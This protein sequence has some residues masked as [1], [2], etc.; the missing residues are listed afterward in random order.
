MDRRDF[1]TIGGLGLA[2]LVLPIHGRA[3]AAEEL[4]STLDV[5]VKKA[6]ADAALEA[7]PRARRHLLPTCA[8]GR[9]LQP[10]RHHPGGQVQNIANTESYGVGVRV[11]ADGTWGFAATTTSPRTASPRRRAQAVA[12]A[13]ANARLQTEPVQ[14]A[15][16][17]GVR[18]G[19]AGR[20]RSRRTPSRCRSRRR[21]TCCWRSTP[22]RSRR[23]PSS[24]TPRSSSSTSRSTSPRPTALHRPGHPPH[25][26]AVHGHRDGPGERQVPDPRRAV[27]RRWAWA[28]STCDGARRQVRWC[29]AASSTTELLRHGRGR[30]AR[31]RSRRGRSSR[32]VGRARAS[33]TWSS[34]H[35][36]LAHHPRVGRAT[37]RARPRARLRGQLRR[38]QLRH[39]RQV[40]E[41]ELQVRQPAGEHRSPTRRSPARS[42]R[43]ATTTKA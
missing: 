11:I 36:P 40:A 19:L 24:S 12:I 10:V 1:L 21:S 26:A 42:A 31:R 29:R 28:T 18:R 9:Y 15:P 38:H 39:A 14:L 41:Q 30:H 8:I 35:A 5:S 3:V 43:S 22:R 33:T 23:A 20:R 17:K 37:H 27:A 2:G 16:L 4:L 6:L 13:K 25:L 34:T 32:Q 7:A